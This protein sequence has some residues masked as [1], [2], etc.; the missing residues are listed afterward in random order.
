M[1]QLSNNLAQYIVRVRRYLRETTAS[2]SHWDDNFVKQIFNTCYRKRCGDLI[3]AYEGYF[4]IIGTRSLVANQGRYAWPTGFSRLSKL[5]VVRSDGRRIPIQRDERHF[6]VAET[7]QVG[8]DQYMPNYRPVGSGFVLEPPPLESVT[9]GLQLEW[10]GV[11]E[12]LTA[13]GDALHSDFPVL[14]DELLVLDTAISLFDAE[15]M[16]ESGQMRTLLRLRQE[17]EQQ[18]EQF[19]ENRMISVQKVVPFIGYFHD[20]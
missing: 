19:I 11:P 4:T 9:D 2:I 3:M 10:F 5:E 7:A 17:W 6:S 1:S 16:Q 8:G 14:Y 12:E 15:G 20:A 18:W 13:D